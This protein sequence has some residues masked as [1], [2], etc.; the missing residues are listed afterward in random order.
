MPDEIDLLRRFR[1]DTPGPD[2]AAWSRARTALADARAGEPG[3]L[4]VPRRRWSRWR[5]PGGRVTIVTVAAV[6][7]AA[8]TVLIINVVQGPPTLTGR[9]TTSWSRLGCCPAALTPFGLPLAP[10][11]S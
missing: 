5:P 3:A 7:A 9:L 8:A 6:V 10:G 1:A 4:D 11:G 2:D